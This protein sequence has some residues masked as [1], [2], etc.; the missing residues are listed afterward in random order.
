MNLIVML[1]VWGTGM[2]ILY[3]WYLAAA[4]R[5]AFREEVFAEPVR[6]GVGEEVGSGGVSGGAVAATRFR[7][8]KGRL[9]VSWDELVEAK[10]VPAVPVDPFDGK[11]IRFAAHKDFVFI[12]TIGRGGVDNGGAPYMVGRGG[13]VQQS[14]L[15]MIIS[16]R[17]LWELDLVPKGFVP[18]TQG[19]E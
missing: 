14:D 1:A 13:A 6:A 7:I 11:P 10:L 9:P 2:V 5:R 17:P 18:A 4:L 15:G 3:G 12:C 19:A 8:Q 16:G